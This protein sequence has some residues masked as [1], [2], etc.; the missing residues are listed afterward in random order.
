[1]STFQIK[2]LMIKVL[3]TGG[4]AGGGADA[5]CVASFVEKVL[6]E[7]GV[8]CT[9]GCSGQACSCNSC[10]APCS[11]GTSAKAQD[12]TACT[13]CTG[14]TC[15]S[16]CTY[17]GCSGC[18]NTL[19]CDAGVTRC[20]GC[21]VCTQPHTRCPEC[22]VCSL[23]TDCTQCSGCSNCSNCTYCTPGCSCT[24]ACTANIYTNCGDCSQYCSRGD[25]TEGK[26]CTFCSCS[27]VTSGF[28]S[29]SDLAALKEQLQERLA[30][31][32]AHDRE[33]AA[34]A[35]PTREELDALEDKLQDAL[36]AVREQKTAAPAARKAAA[37]KGV[38][39]KTRK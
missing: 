29:R 33:L 3:P 31:V 21:S 16:P 38:R 36:T 2:D 35:R 13:W 22:S 4:N 34:D 7:A 26:N 25:C 24:Q 11:G 15:T 20:A 23:C 28:T 30:Q 39:R 32:E 27:A 12:C 8:M 10:S 6:A 5:A 14:C 9:A 37:Q 17:L 18:T 1:M 19:K